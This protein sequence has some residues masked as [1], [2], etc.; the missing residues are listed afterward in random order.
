M[1]REVTSGRLHPAAGRAQ[2]AL[3]I[4]QQRGI[5]CVPFVNVPVMNAQH[6]FVQPVVLESIVHGH[7]VSDTF[8]LQLHSPVVFCWFLAPRS[9]LLELPF[10][11][12]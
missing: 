10:M 6:V 4:A 12:I 2:P 5:R 3:G 1:R 7:D 9:C 8:T 11:R